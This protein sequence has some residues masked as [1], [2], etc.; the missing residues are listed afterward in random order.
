MKKILFFTSFL[1]SIALIWY[2]YVVN[3][4]YQEELESLRDNASWTK[5][6]SDV[7]LILGNRQ[8]TLANRL[9]CEA[10]GDLVMKVADTRDKSSWIEL[11]QKRF[12]E[13]VE[14][15]R[16]KSR[17]DKIKKK[18]AAESNR[19]LELELK[20]TASKDVYKAIDVG[21]KKPFWK[22]STQAAED[23]TKS[24]MGSR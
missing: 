21:L 19:I 4:A 9:A 11:R 14:A 18:T 22:G 2:C 5:L 20:Y 17:L 8:P 1:A 24:C 13:S 10:G 7:A 16:E 12:I 23:F 6:S 3:S 15:F